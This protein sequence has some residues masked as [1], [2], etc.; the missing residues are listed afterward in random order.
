MFGSMKPI[1]WFDHLSRRAVVWLG[2]DATESPL[3][4]RDVGLGFL[5][6]PA[7]LA[8][9]ML[10]AEFK[11]NGV[12]WLCAVVAVVS[13]SLATKRHVLGAALFGI[14]AIR[15]GF[16][17]IVQRSWLL[18]LVGAAFLGIALAIVYTD[19]TNYPDQDSGT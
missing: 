5:F 14:L 8:M 12:F 10:A 3:F 17:S 4:Y 16:G 9:S 1:H 6:A 18:L 2:G 19:R 7:V 15:F 13:L 11:F